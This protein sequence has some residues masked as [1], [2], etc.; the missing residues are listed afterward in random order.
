[1]IIHVNEIYLLLN[2]IVAIVVSISLAIILKV[3]ILPEK[4]RRFSNTASA[5]FPTPIIAIGL[6]AVFFSLGFYWLYNGLI[7]AIIMGVFSAI[8]V[9][10]GFKHIFP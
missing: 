10:F 1:M 2:Y 3:P 9:K 6:L 5:I 7:L 4:P 8:F